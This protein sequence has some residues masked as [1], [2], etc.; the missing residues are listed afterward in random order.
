M[1]RILEML[2]LIFIWIFAIEMSIKMFGVGFK[3]YFQIGFNCF[4]CAVVMLRYAY[5]VSYTHLT[6]PTIYSV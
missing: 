1:T 2:N 6:L 4:D 5:T 3:T